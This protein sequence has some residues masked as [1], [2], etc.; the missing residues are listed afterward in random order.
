M[1]IPKE[2]NTYCGKCRQHTKHK[3]TQ[4]KRRGH[5]ANHTLARGQKAR[6]QLRGLW[7]GFGNLGRYSRPPIASRK[8][9]GKKQ[10]KNTDLRYTCSKCKKSH[11]QNHGV[12][13]KK[14]EFKQ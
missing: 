5:G 6:V 14:V 10:S 8:R 7:R 1:K 9:S 3:V 11:T 13:A 12:R 4:A 2:R